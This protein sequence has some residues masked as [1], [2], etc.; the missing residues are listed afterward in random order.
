[1]T[2]YILSSRHASICTDLISSAPCQLQPVQPGYPTF[3]E[4]VVIDMPD[5]SYVYGLNR[6]SGQLAV[7]PDNEQIDADLFTKLFKII[8]SSRITDFCGK[9]RRA[10]NQP[11]V[12]R[13]ATTPKTGKTIPSPFYPLNDRLYYM[14]LN[15]TG[16][17]SVS[18]VYIDKPI[19]SIDKLNSGEDFSD[20]W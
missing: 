5:D 15:D 10:P 1:M 16:S 11:Y 13:S 9:N 4:R 18:S 7:T 12:S 20:T 14:E 8:I 3:V 2:P 6:D 19:D 17:F